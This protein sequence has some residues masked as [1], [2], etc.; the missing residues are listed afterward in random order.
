MIDW[1]DLI[2]NALW[3]ISLAVVLASLAYASWEA[4][5]AQEKFR[6][7]LGQPKILICLNIG[8]LLFCIGLAGTS[9][10]I[11]QRI[12]WILLALGFVVQIGVGLM[13]QIKNT[14]KN[15]SK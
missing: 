7:R 3:I 1:Y 9:E 5:V 12:L 2:M 8:G 4:S 14:Q 13:Q 10:I 15:S 11:W 6:V